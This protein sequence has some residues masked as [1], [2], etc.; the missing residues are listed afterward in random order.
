MK[1]WDVVTAFKLSI[2]NFK[3]V[4][5]LIHSLRQPFMRIRH[6]E[7]LQT[8]LDFDPESPTFTFD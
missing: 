4:L 6:W 3:S 8:N 2:E 7:E 1:K 5:P